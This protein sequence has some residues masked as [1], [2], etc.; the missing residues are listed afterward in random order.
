M[1][2]ENYWDYISTQDLIDYTDRGDSTN[3]L[4]LQSL[5]F[6]SP[7]LNELCWVDANILYLQAYKI[8]QH[9]IAQYLNIS[10][11]GVSKR[12]RR[13]MERL[14]VKLSRPE[15]DYNKAQREL[16]LAF[17]NNIS[18]VMC[19]YMFNNISLVAH[20]YGN[21]ARDEVIDRIEAF[22][23]AEALESILKSYGLHN[24]N[25]AELK[26][27]NEYSIITENIDRI[28]VIT[29]KYSK[30]F[31]MI[32]KDSTIGEMVFNKMNRNKIWED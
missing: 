18:E 11:Y 13:A 25:I 30:Y 17:G 3:E 7:Y 28:L 2:K 31:D 26:L 10:Q 21:N 9:S 19:L 29:K 20:L 27:K 14:K 24:L 1:N 4:M 12:Q 22:I 32:L 5:D 8:P 6:I 23:N 15:N 16:T